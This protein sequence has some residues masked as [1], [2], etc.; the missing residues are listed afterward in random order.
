M[1]EGW[2]TQDFDPLAFLMAF[3]SGE[4]TFAETVSRS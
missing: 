4:V 1:A 3:D 2:P